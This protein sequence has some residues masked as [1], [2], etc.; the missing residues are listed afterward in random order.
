MPVNDVGYRIN[1]PDP[2]PP[3]AAPRVEPVDGD[4]IPHP[5]HAWRGIRSCARAGTPTNAMC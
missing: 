4:E 5:P 2:D 3:L 1:F